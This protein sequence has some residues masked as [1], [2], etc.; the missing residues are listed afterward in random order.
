LLHFIF[1]YARSIKYIKGQ[2]QGQ[3]LVIAHSSRQSHHRGAKVHGA[4][5]AASHSHILPA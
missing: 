2:G 3:T 4:H 5:Q 1:V